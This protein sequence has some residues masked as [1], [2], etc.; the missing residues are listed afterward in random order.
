M[1]YILSLIWQAVTKLL[2]RSG[3]DSAGIQALR[4]DVQK[5]SQD[6]QDLRAKLDEILIL[7]S[8]AQAER[9]VFIAEVDGRITY[10]VEKMNLAYTQQ[11]PVSI[12]P[13]AKKGNPAPVD[14]APVWTS[15]NTE[16]VTVTA[17]AD[18]MS[19]MITPVGGMGGPTTITVTADADLGSGVTPIIGT[20]D[21]T[22]TGGQAVSI[23]IV[24]GTPVDL[25]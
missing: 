20:L 3:Q 9:I 12:Q 14:G 21:I 5:L 2:E 19:A 25:P 15:S 7:L 13:V 6:V 17:A 22:V 24:P 23:T 4:T 18:G 1:L 11:L 10:G 16:L 8:P